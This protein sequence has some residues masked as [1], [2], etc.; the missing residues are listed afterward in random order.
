[1]AI[2]N[3]GPGGVG[4]NYGVRETV[5]RERYDLTKEYIEEYTDA[6]GKVVTG[7][8]D[9]VN[10]GSTI[11]TPVSSL[12]LPAGVTDIADLGGGG[13]ASPFDAAV[14]NVKSI[15]YLAY[16]D[17]VHDDTAA[18]QAAID[19]CPEY[20]A[21]YFPAACVYLTTGLIVNKSLRLFAEGAVPWNI[22]GTQ[23]TGSTTL[24]LTQV[25]GTL[26]KY[27]GVDNAYI[28]GP[29]I[30]GL[31]LSATSGATAIA[32]TLIDASRCI[33]MQ[34]ERVAFRRC[35]GRALS[36]TWFTQEV[37]IKGCTF[38]EV[39]ADGDAAVMFRDYVGAANAWNINNLNIVDCTFGAVGG[40]CI[41]SEALSNATLIR[42]VNNKFEFDHN[43]PYALSPTVRRVID[44]KDA[45]RWLIQGNNF[46]YYEIGRGNHDAI[47]HAT[48]TGGNGYSIQVSD[49]TYT[50]T[51]ANFVKSDGDAVFTGSGNTCDAFG[52]NDTTP[53]H[54]PFA[55]TSTYRQLIEPVIF[56]DT[57]KKTEFWYDDAGA[58]QGHNVP[59]P[60][61][62]SS[63]KLPTR[64][65]GVAQ[66]QVGF[67]ADSASMYHIKTSLKLPSGAV[68][69]AFRL[70]LDHMQGWSDPYVYVRARFKAVTADS[71]VY[72]VLYQDAA[73]AGLVSCGA[74]KIIAGAGYTWVTF[75]VP[76]SKLTAD[77]HLNVR[78]DGLGGDVY[79]DGAYVDSGTA[80]SIPAP[81]FSIPAAVA[82]N[83]LV[84]CVRA[85]TATYFGADGLLHNADANTV[86]YDHYIG[87]STY[88]GILIEFAATNSAKW[89]RDATQT[90]WV[91][92]N[93][94]AALTATGIDGAANSASTLT[95]SANAGTCLQTVTA[96]ANTRRVSTYVKRVTGTG[97]IE[98]TGDGGVTWT[99]ITSQLSAAFT[100]FSVLTTVANPQIGFRIA[101]SGDAIAFD[102]AQIELGNVDAISTSPIYTT[103]AAVT[104]AADTLYVDGTN[105]SGFYNQAAGSIVCDYE[106]ITATGTTNYQRSPFHFT[107]GTA[108]TNRIA[109][110]VDNTGQTAYRLSAAGVSGIAVTNAIEQSATH[111]KHAMSWASREVAAAIN[112]QTVQ[113]GQP[114]AVNAA[115]TKLAIGNNGAATPALHLNGWIRSLDYR[116]AAI[117]AAEMAA[118]TV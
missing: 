23:E 95:A 27:Q 68:R 52:L 50:Q 11:F 88:R 40:A 22:F 2:E 33:G 12:K 34:L 78:Y 94:T 84:T 74:Q 100:R 45:S 26:L 17:G 36:L 21:V 110:W 96:S 31:C 61:F 76:V 72:G 57:G 13:S 93:V 71:Y 103:T 24:R 7:K 101:T 115:N 87:T 75:V 41:A 108:S 51:D 6:D 118:L 29:I 104:R 60:K 99:D 66:E 19:A 77:C 20:G 98:M 10:G 82:A 89:C 53:M 59:D 69:E 83:P 112:S 81:A 65:D 116:A 37:R 1:M 97:V 5:A 30:S 16:G 102:Y 3:V 73:G 8:V 39:G 105:F 46:T 85:G 92:S 64:T 49:N 47:I 35:N 54:T 62:I 44:I 25:G 107:D 90:A 9:P 56:T 79:F 43:P 14:I 28:D 32:G 4:N 117:G 111:R 67:F 70:R 48:G 80:L 113:L 91:K 18:I 15:P 38:N 42:I 86:R 114:A 58:S 106:L 55:I 109:A 63:H